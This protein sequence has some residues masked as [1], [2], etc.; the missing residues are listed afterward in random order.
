MSLEDKE[1]RFYSEKQLKEIANDIDRAITIPVNTLIE[2]DHKVF[3][4]SEVE[5]I[6]RSANRITVHDCGCRTEYDNCESPR[7]VC[8][9]LDE[10]ADYA[11]N[12]GT[13]NV[14]EIDIEEALGV[15]RRSHE[16]GLVHMAY[17]FKDEENPG[18]ICSCCSCCCH[19]LGGLL[20]YGIHTQVLSSKLISFDDSD[21]CI[22]CGECIQRCVFNARKLSENKLIYEE[23]K[24]MG[25]GLCVSICPT[26]AISMI[27]RDT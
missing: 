5:K 25:C 24:C 15:L 8:I 7:D 17:V 11:L 2:A 14:K 26:K 13:C 6:L 21:S 18:L 3:D 9:S 20:R 23:T 16:A 12:Q 22:N 10:E 4:L 27:P 1:T 19:T